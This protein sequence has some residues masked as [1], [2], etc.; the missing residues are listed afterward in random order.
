MELRQFFCWRIETIRL[1]VAI[2]HIHSFALELIGFRQILI[3]IR[4][5]E[6][7]V[8]CG[9]TKMSQKGYTIAGELMQVQRMSAICARQMR[10]ALKLPHTGWQ[11]FGC[12]IE[13][14]Q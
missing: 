4:S 8:A 9:V 3:Q 10:D 7:L 1:N 13:E 11:L 14:A 6:D 12:Q 5:E 2:D